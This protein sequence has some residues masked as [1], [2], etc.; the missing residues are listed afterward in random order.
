VERY[1]VN[2]AKPMTLL[3]SAAAVGAI[4]GPLLLGQV[5]AQWHWTTSLHCIGLAHLAL[6]LGAFFVRFPKPPALGA[7][8][9]ASAQAVVSTALIPFALIALFYVGVEM[10]ISVF[11]APYAAQGL[12]LDTTAGQFAISIFWMGLFAGRIATLAAPRI[13]GVRTLIFAGLFSCTVLVIGTA[14]G[15]NHA[16]IF[17]GLTGFALGP[18][19]P[20]MI[21]LVGQRFPQACGAATG[22]A[23]GAGA[24][25]GFAIPWFTGAIGD[26]IGI[27]FAVGSLSVSCLAIALGSVGIRREQARNSAV[28]LL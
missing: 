8:R 27:G 9:E 1:G 16:G 5:S 28:R 12:P 6:A 2:S 13:P 14:L 17:L 23:A 24:I 21:S 7:P 3:H 18:V 22:L 15:P 11:A 4:T 26:G 20:V 19:Y 25:G 10:G